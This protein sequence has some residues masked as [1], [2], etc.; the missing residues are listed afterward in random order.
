MINPIFHG[1]IALRNQNMAPEY[2]NTEEEVA[3]KTTNSLTQV[4]NQI[5]LS[6]TTGLEWLVP[7]STSDHGVCANPCMLMEYRP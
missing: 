5:F 6:K 1:E 4:R 2:I 3:A 7:I